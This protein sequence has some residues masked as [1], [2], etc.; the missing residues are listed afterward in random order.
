MSESKPWTRDQII[1]ATVGGITILVMLLLG[2][3]TYSQIEKHR[4]EDL[5]REQWEQQREQAAKA[6]E[7]YRNRPFLKH[8]G[9]LTTPGRDG[10]T[11]IK[12]QNTSSTK[13]AVISS[14]ELQVSDPATLD[15]IAKYQPRVPPT[16]GAIVDKQEVRLIHGSWNHG[17]ATYTFYVYPDFYVEPDKPIELATC[18]VDPKLP[19]MDLAGQLFITVSSGD[20]DTPMSVTLR[21]RQ[22]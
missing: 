1:G 11:R 16:T 15:R 10:F 6:E 21:S 14:I 13:N 2:W 19:V 5:L 3:A 17:F 7:E 18:I 8:I 12:F 22:R 4:K 9:G 20:S